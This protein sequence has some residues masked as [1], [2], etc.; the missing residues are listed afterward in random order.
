M[1]LTALLLQ[2]IA[3][4]LGGNAV[5]YLAKDINLGTLGHSIGGGIGAQILSSILAVG[6][7]AAGSDLDIGTIVSAFFWRDQWRPHGLGR[8]LSES[9]MAS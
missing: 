5:G 3:G 6:G 8:R 2:P 4:A 1:T 7:A 9:K